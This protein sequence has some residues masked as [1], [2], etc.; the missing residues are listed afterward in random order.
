MPLALVSRASAGFVACVVAIALAS[1]AVAE[2][3]DQIPGNGVFQVGP[4]IAPGLYHTNGPSNP[5]ILI[6]GKVSD[7]ST[8]SWFTH[9]TPAASKQDVVET[10]SSLSP[11]YANV[12]ATVKAFES[13]NCQPW[14]RVS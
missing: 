7:L 12:P 4:D 5:L 2:P 1:P 14:T 11:M 3:S 6:F 10:N 13:M 9:S 8:C